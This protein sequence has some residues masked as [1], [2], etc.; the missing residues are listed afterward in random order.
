MGF[1]LFT[2]Q[3]TD[4][5]FEEAADPSLEAFMMWRELGP[6]LEITALATK[7]SAQRKGRMQALFG[8]FFN[9]FCQNREVWL[10][11]HAEN[12][13]ARNVYEKIGFLQTG[14]R[15]RYYRDGGDAILY[16][17]KAAG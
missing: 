5:P 2:N 6:E 15:P 11:V 10:E 9:T 7:P 8:E 13:T 1:G 17:R 4:Q 14:L 3:L 16:R 12:R